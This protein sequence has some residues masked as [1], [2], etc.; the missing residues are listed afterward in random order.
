[1]L[2]VSCMR[3]R[4]HCRPSYSCWFVN[5]L[6]PTR[7]HLS[8]SASPCAMWIGLP[9]APT[10]L[11]CRSHPHLR[12][13]PPDPSGITRS[14]SLNFCCAI[15]YRFS[16]ICPSLVSERKWLAICQLFCC[17][18]LYNLQLL[19]CRSQYVNS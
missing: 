3:L 6:S 16:T 9:R 13:T 7:C 8:Q 14:F 15:T 19:C 4:V 17:R 1:M 2:A 10:S 11:T 18:I 5:C 12:H